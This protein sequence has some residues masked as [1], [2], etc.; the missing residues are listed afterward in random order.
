MLEELEHQLSRNMLSARSQAAAIE[1]LLANTELQGAF[2]PVAQTTRK[3]RFK[4]ALSALAAF[5]AML[6]STTA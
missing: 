4:A 2:E 3:L 6:A 1:Q 5:S